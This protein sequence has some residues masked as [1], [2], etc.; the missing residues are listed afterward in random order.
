WDRT[1]QMSTRSRRDDR[2]R[3]ADIHQS[4]RLGAGFLRNFETSQEVHGKFADPHALFL[5][6]FCD[7]AASRNNKRTM[8]RPFGCKH[9]PSCVRN[10]EATQDDNYR[11]IVPASRSAEPAD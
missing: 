6:F 10:F 9:A 8:V 5:F 7:T 1:R 2:T 3:D 4:S 11:L